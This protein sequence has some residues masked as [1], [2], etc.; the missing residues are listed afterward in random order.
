MPLTGSDRRVPSA[1][2]EPQGV[3][4]DEAVAASLLAEVE[5]S[6]KAIE[7]QQVI[8]REAISTPALSSPSRR[9]LVGEHIRQLVNGTDESNVSRTALPIIVVGY[10][11]YC[12]I[13]TAA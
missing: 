10:G 11:I 8:V 2:R 12:T 3:K 7:L 5:R 9:G 1:V 6:I 13:P 4:W